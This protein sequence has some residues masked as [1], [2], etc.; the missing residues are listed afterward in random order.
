MRNKAGEDFKEA[1]APKG[2]DVEGLT[3]ES[4]QDIDLV[5]RLCVG[6]PPVVDDG[7][8]R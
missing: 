1:E 4:R 3:R 8:W 5:E 2:K 6:V 7:D